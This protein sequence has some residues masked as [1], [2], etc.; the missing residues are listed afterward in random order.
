MAPLTVRVRTKAAMLRFT[1]DDGA[2]VRRLKDEVACCCVGCRRL[3]RPQP[4]RC[5]VV[6]RLRC[7]AGG[8]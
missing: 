5:V 7:G 6:V 2:T 8:A 4:L 1:L 3:P